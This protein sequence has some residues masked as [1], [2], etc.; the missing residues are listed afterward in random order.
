MESFCYLCLSVILSPLFLAALQWVKADLLALL[1]VMFSCV[2]IT[3]PFG[4]LGQVW[5]LI[6]SIPALCILLYYEG[7]HGIQVQRS[8]TNLSN[9]SDTIFC[10]TYNVHCKFEIFITG[11]MLVSSCFRRKVRIVVHQK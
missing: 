1:Y 2:F 8:T 10:S 9:S 6:V 3:F 11:E 4:V 5:Y 7:L